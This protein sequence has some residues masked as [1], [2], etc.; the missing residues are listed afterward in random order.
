LKQVVPVLVFCMYSVAVYGQTSSTDPTST[1][2]LS[3]APTAN[4]ATTL[5]GGFFRGDFFNASAF[6]NGVYDTV[7]QTLGRSSNLGGIGFAFGGAASA[8][9]S[10]SDSILSLSYR[11]EYR[12]YASGFGG[13]GTNQDLSLVYSKRLSNRWQ[14]T[15][16]E[17]A[18]MLLYGTTAYSVNPD[19]PTIS[20]P[21]SPST[22]FVQSSVTATYQQSARLSYSVTGAFIL[23]RYSFAGAFGMTGGTASGS[24]NYLLSQRTKVSLT[25]TH[26]EYRYTGEGGSSSINGMFATVSHTFGRSWLAK[27]SAGASHV[28]T[29]GIYNLPVIIDDNGTPVSG[30]V[31][32]PY[33]VNKAIPTFNASLAHSIGRFSLSGVFSHGVNPG[34]GTYLTSSNTAANGYISRNFGSSSVFTVSAGLNRLTSVASGLGQSYSQ[35]QFSAYYSRLIFPHVSAQGTYQLIN[36]SSISNYGSTLDNRFM[37]GVSVSLKNVPTTLF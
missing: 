33:N 34:N 6:V 15:F 20:N 28:S 37:F 29:A 17:Q 16:Q 32:F 3:P 31:R 18:G 35:T 24:V 7:Q 23:N 22:R 26:D 27:V 30:Y 8:S 25:Y 14:L 13:T 12:D 2:P 5:Q 21:F 10:F 36:Y 4:T 19:S 11:G 1:T 9:K